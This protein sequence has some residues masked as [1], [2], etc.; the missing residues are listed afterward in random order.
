M[1]LV[2]L[3][4]N[5]LILEYCQ[6]KSGIFELPQ[7]KLSFRLKESSRFVEIFDSTLAHEVFECVWK[8]VRFKLYEK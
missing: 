1:C 6:L 7:K 8:Q 4:A 5:E 2:W 3:C